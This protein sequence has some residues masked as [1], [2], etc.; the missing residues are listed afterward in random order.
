[1]GA[2]SP[3]PTIIVSLDTQDETIDLVSDL[4]F[5]VQETKG[6]LPLWLLWLLWL[7]WLLWLLGYE[8]LLKLFAQFVAQYFAQ[9]SA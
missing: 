3:S 5:E 4:R 7:R 2:A 9:A 6:L 8:L 1:M